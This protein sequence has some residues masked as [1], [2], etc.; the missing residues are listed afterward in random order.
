MRITYDPDKNARNSA[1]RGLS[2]DE[3]A[4]LDWKTAVS[5]RDDRRNY[6]EE[7]YRVFGRIGEQLFTVV[8][9]PREGDEVRVISF[10]RANRREQVIYDRQREQERER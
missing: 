2:F 3:V 4:D 1:E 5:T 10:R 9:T 7:R 6:G 8:F